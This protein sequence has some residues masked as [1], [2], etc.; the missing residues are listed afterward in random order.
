M[1]HLPRLG[2][3]DHFLATGNRRRQAR[4]FMSN[5]GKISC[6]SEVIVLSPFFKWVMVTL[7]TF[8]PD[9]EEQLARH[10]G[11]LVGCAAI[12]KKCRS[13]VVPGASLSRDNL[14]HELVIRLVAAKTVSN[15]MVVVQYRFDSDPIGI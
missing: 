2:N 10:G 9:P 14:T 7:C 5:A 4:S 13:A 11:D 6:Q 12:T 15:P 3:N 8:E 1:F